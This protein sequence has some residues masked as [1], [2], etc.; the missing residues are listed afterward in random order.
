MDIK[1]QELMAALSKVL[2]VNNEVK[3]SKALVRPSIE[4][5]ATDIFANEPAWDHKRTYEKVYEDCENI[6]IEFA[7][8]WALKGKRN[9]KEFNHLDPNTYF[10]DVTAFSNIANRDIL[11]ECKR[12]KRQGGDFFSYPTK[13]LKTLIKHAEK[14]DFVVA[15][16]LYPYD[17]HYIIE[18]KQIMDAP[19]FNLFLQKSKH[20]NWESWYNHYKDTKYSAKIN[21]Q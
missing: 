2:S 19:T 11:F 15:A 18:F 17:D 13:K 9:E 7:L 8:A 3:I 6:V 1:K 16:K 21:V 14:L 20:N 12:W 5:M 10:Y 4:K